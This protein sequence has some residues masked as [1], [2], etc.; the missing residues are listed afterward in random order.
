MGRRPI[1]DEPSRWGGGYDGHHIRHDGEDIPVTVRVRWDDGTES[2]H[3]GTTGQWTRTHVFVAFDD[4]PSMWVL[5]S[6]V[7]RQRDRRCPRAKQAGQTRFKAYCT[8][9]GRVVQEARELATMSTRDA[10]QPALLG[11]LR[12]AFPWGVLLITDDSSTEQIPTWDS[13]EVQVSAGDTAAVLRVMHAQE[14]D[15]TVQVWHQPSQP[16]GLEV[17][18]GQ[19]HLPSGTLRISDATNETAPRV[20]LGPGRHDISIRTDPD[21]VAQASTIHIIV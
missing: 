9:A 15:V 11:Q 17:Y 12:H 13:S 5:A 7:K 16:M 3:P 2:E 14:G 18:Q 6:E 19:I 20:R 21:R 8:R 10:D 1:E 4:L